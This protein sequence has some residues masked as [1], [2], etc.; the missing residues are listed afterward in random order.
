MPDSERLLSREEVAERLGLS[1]LTVGAMLRDGRLP[2]FHMG[3]LWRVRE[4]D[5]NDYV[6]ELAEAGGDE[7]R[8]RA[9]KAKARTAPNAADKANATRGPAGRSEAS[10][11]ANATRKARARGDGS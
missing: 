8:K 2:G 6:R 10:R 7:R 9:A 11:K 3:R 1:V 4:A 5:L